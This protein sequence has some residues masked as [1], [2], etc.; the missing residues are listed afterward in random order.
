M[1]KPT[2]LAPGIREALERRNVQ[3]QENVEAAKRLLQETFDELQEN[4]TVLDAVRLL[5]K[6]STTVIADPVT[7]EVPPAPQEEPA[8]QEQPKDA[9]I[10]RE[11]SNNA[12][13]IRQLICTYKTRASSPKEW[14]VLAV[15]AK[16]STDTVPVLANHFGQALGRA[17]KC[18]FPWLKTEQVGARFRY[19]YNPEFTSTTSV[20]P[21][22][23]ITTTAPSEKPPVPTQEA[24]RRVLEMHPKM[25]MTVAEITVTAKQAG[26]APG[27]ALAVL[28][29]RYGVCLSDLS[30]RKSWIQKHR[31]PNT[32]IR[33]F[34]WIPE[35]GRPSGGQD[36]NTPPG[37]KGKGT[38][39]NFRTYKDMFDLM[40]QANKGQYRR[41]T[42]WATM[43]YDL[44]YNLAHRKEPIT[45]TALAEQFNAVSQ[46]HLKGKGDTW[47]VR[48]ADPSTG[49]WTYACV[50]PE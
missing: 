1:S 10:I 27:V 38:V 17:R 21:P 14:A 20:I 18:S 2:D 29:K 15:E 5:S 31:K 35:K 7:K 19:T 11:Y 23:P 16:L 33:T 42:G 13:L 24:I 12:D 37:T 49:K 43:A 34:Q 28:K 36:T 44:G 50:I 22:A 39:R 8:T 9:P 3:L 41:I 26:F 4:A 30:T 6:T 40:L 48:K 45:I 47:L 46:N 32:N 25:R